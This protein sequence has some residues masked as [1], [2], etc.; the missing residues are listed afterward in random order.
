MRLPTKNYNEIIISIYW[1]DISSEPDIFDWLLLDQQIEQ[2]IEARNLFILSVNHN[3]REPW[4]YLHLWH[5]SMVQELGRRYSKNHSLYGI[6]MSG[7]ISAFSLSEL[8][9]GWE[10]CFDQY[11]KAF[12]NVG[13][14]YRAD[15]NKSLTQHLTNYLLAELP[16]QGIVKEFPHVSRRSKKQPHPNQKIA[17]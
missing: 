3:K 5:S 4:R 15:S 2:C 13:L 10:T 9:D 16:K 7:P 8:I 6:E 17:G 12:P 1:E 11:K 14:I